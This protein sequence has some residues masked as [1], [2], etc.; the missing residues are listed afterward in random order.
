[1]IKEK[2]KPVKK[3]THT[4]NS[5]LNWMRKKRQDSEK[6]EKKNVKKRTRASK[7]F[8][9]K[10]QEQQN[11][12]K[13]LIS[14]EAFEDSDNEEEEYN[15]YEWRSFRHYECAKILLD[16]FTHFPAPINSNTGKLLLE[17]EK[18]GLI[19]YFSKFLPYLN[20]YITCRLVLY[21]IMIV[22]AQNLPTLQILPLLLIEL[23]VTYAV[24]IGHFQHQ[25]FETWGFFRYMCQQ[26][27]IVLLLT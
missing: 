10:M 18:F 16:N 14:D 8:I 4:S 6:V 3:S 9:K 17:D 19:T 11:L 24:L 15:P 27:T 2:K 1:V 22:G 25:C 7:N 21:E 5:L 13:K 12:S 26:V 20:L 23:F